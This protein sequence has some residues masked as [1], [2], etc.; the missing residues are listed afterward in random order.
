M[1]STP[2]ITTELSLVYRIISFRSREYA[3]EE[4]NTRYV[5]VSLIGSELPGKLAAKTKPAI[6]AAIIALYED[7]QPEPPTAPAA[8]SVRPVREMT[9]TY[10]VSN[11]KREH[12]MNIK[13]THA[14]E[15][16]YPY[17]LSLMT[18]IERFTQKYGTKPTLIKSS[19]EDESYG[20]AEYRGIPVVVSAT[21]P[22]GM[23]HVS[24]HPAEAPTNEHKVNITPATRAVG[25]FYDECRVT[26]D[27]ARTHFQKKYGVSPT[28]AR[29]NPYFRGNSQ[30][31]T[32][33]FTDTL[34]RGQFWLGYDSTVASAA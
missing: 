3:V 30:W 6:K 2:N 19:T 1:S 31:V 13:P 23:V 24:Y 26:L 32:V 18:M 17:E 14:A 21:V 12:V 16:Y 15:E 27:E 22:E 28:I 8:V 25:E 11:S 5:L 34:R 4:F 29:V 20:F 33:E 9:R 7:M 10:A